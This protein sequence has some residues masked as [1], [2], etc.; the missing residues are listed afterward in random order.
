MRFLEKGKIRFLGLKKNFYKGGGGWLGW[1]C[2]GGEGE[3]GFVLWL[4]RVMG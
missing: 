3:R 1:Y 2:M 4:G